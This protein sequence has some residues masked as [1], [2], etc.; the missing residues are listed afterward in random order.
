MI[1]DH[2]GVSKSCTLRDFL[3]FFSHEAVRPGCPLR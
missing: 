3:P 1:A 2:C